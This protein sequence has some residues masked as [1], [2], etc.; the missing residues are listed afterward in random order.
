MRPPSW[1]TDLIARLVADGDLQ[2]EVQA[3][4]EAIATK[5]PL[6]LARMKA[7]VAD[8]QQLSADDAIRHELDVV[9]EHTASADFAEGLAAFAQKRVPEFSGR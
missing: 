7:L 3:L 1:R 6:G 8:G 9:A 4:A 5:S 2:V